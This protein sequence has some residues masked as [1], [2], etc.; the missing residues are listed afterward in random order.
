MST[1]I[2]RTLG[3]VGGTGPAATAFAFSRLISLCQTEYGAT[4]DTDF[5][6]IIVTN[7]PVPGV[8]ETGPDD[9]NDTDK[10]TRHTLARSYKILTDAGA[11]IIYMACN[12]LQSHRPAKNNSSVIEVSP[13]DE[14]LLYIQTAYPSARVLVLS[15]RYTSDHQL[16][17][18]SPFADGL[19]FV[20][21]TAEMQ[22]IVDQ[23]ILGGMSGKD[24]A[25]DKSTLQA[26][27]QQ[28]KEKADVVI[29]G[30]TELSLLA[31]QQAIEQDGVVDAQE[32]AL[33]KLL[34]I[35]AQS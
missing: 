6:N 7:L 25:K 34:E 4:Q 24:L 16:Y 8:S 3:I 29:L 33:H 13:I 31:N 19:N 22:D 30:C 27:C 14:C 2:T 35:G 28:A 10:A 23:L 17:Q 21:A 32:A 20:Q 1:P 11:E 12:T 5:P 15:S 9:K 18:A 26:L